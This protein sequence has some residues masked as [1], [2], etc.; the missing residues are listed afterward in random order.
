MKTPALKVNSLVVEAQRELFGW[1]PFAF[2]KTLHPSETREGVRLRLRDGRWQLNVHAAR[3]AN[4]D[5]WIHLRNVK[6]WIEKRQPEVD[7]PP[8]GLQVAPPA[9]ASEAGRG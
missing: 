8:A 3:G 9:A 4:K 7:P 6:A 1:V 2:W 5:L